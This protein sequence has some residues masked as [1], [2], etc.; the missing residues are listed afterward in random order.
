MPRESKR[1]R[2]LRDLSV[3]LD[4]RLQVRKARL[5]LGVKDE[6]DDELDDFLLARVQAVV[7]ARYLSPRVYLKRVPRFSWSM[8]ECSDR[9]FLR[10]F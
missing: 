7:R 4:R 10:S 6:C 5:A 1:S 9:E 8:T 2:L 3:L